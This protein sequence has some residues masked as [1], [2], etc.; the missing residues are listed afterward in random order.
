MTGPGRQELIVLTGPIGAGKS[1]VAQLLAR[2]CGA[3]G[4]TAANVD[5]DDVA[6]MQDGVH[7]P[8]ELWRRGGIAHVALVRAWYEAGMDVVIAHGP[9]FETGAYPDLFA[10]AP[11]AARVRHVLLRAS[12]DVALARVTR[13]PS[14]GP[15][16][17][18]TRPDFLRRTHDTFAAIV[19]RLPPVDLTIDTDRRT[20]EAVA[21]AIWTH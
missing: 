9:F 5:L 7:D 12:Y 18:S 1:T 19:E 8:P 6:F 10:A 15:H 13:D 20:A 14:R 16:A 21:D 4:Q 17:V 2:R 3:S 11:A